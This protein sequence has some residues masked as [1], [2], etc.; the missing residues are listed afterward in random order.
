MV[1]QL[2]LQLKILIKGRRRP[3]LGVWENFRGL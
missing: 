1:K 2:S 3:E